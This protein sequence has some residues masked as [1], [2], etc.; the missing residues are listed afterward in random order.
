MPDFLRN[1]AETASGSMAAGHTR[2]SPCVPSLHLIS[3][4]VDKSWRKYWGVMEHTQRRRVTHMCGMSQICVACHTYVWHV[5]HIKR[6]PVCCLL[7]SACHTWMVMSHTYERVMSHTWTSH[8]TH[9]NESCHRREEAMSNIWKSHVAHVNES[10]PTYERVILRI[11]MSHVTR[12][13]ASC[14]TCKHKHPSRVYMKELLSHVWRSHVPREKE[15]R[16]T[17][18]WVMAH[19][20]RRHGTCVRKTIEKSLHTPIY[21]QKSPIY[22][23]KSPIYSQKSPI[24]SKKSLSILSRA[25]YTL[26]RAL[27]TRKRA[28][29]IIKRALYAFKRS[30]CHL[31]RALYT[32]KRAMDTRKR[33]LHARKWALYTTYFHESPNNTPYE[34][35]LQIHF[36]SNSLCP[37]NVI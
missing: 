34:Q 27:Y 5:T 15:S 31:Q 30:L 23:Q 6:R 24:Y 29:Q 20:K 4:W 26:S 7:L 2:F 36:T 8:V 35:K 32:P 14:H 1:L 18:E 25:L 37:C 13:N 33:A 10:Y 12:M 19:I 9:M 21:S 22:S 28:L 17:W 11:R 16:H 3:A